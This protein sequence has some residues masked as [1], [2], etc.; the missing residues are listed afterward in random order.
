MKA[1]IL[2]I[3]DDPASL[4]FMR[5]MLANAGHDIAA[6]IDGAAGLRAARER[7][8]DL[9]VSDAELPEI[10]GSEL[11]KVL[12]MD[13]KMRDIPLV[14]VTANAMPTDREKL[15]GDGFDGYLAKPLVPESVV[16]Q[17]EAFLPGAG[18]GK[19]AAAAEPARSNKERFFAEMA[20]GFAEK[21]PGN[22]ERLRCLAAAGDLGGL[23][24]TAHKVLGSCLFL[25]DKRL[26]EGLRRLEKLAEAGDEGRI[27][28]A[29]RE[30]EEA[31]LVS[32]FG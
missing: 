25:K 9:I 31:A 14:A 30:V 29:L 11:A 24:K 21:L 5:Y 17:I 26:I 16:S 1:H 28:T 23:K 3:D 4:E 7:R 15:L 19:P 10:S 32:N 27:E 8:P 22:L 12:K 2:I 20:A 13:Q 18:T 6:A